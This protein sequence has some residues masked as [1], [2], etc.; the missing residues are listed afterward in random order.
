MHV[1]STPFVLGIE[2]LLLQIGLFM[3]E[4]VGC[5]FSLFIY[6]FSWLLLIIIVVFPA[7]LSKNG[8]S[9]L[10]NRTNLCLI[11]YGKVS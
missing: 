11:V 10:T 8:S 4:D 1:S 2:E 5:C 3:M 6:F 9:I 7:Q